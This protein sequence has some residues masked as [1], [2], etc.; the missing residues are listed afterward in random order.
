MTD[1]FFMV[2]PFEVRVIFFLFDDVLECLV[3]KFV[4]EHSFAA[5]GAPADAA[6][7]AH[8]TDVDRLLLEDRS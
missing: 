4:F 2:V 3:I 1:A 7:D 5:K 6:L 8:V